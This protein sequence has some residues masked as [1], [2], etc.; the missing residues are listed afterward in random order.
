[1]ANIRVK[2]AEAIRAQQEREYAI[3]RTCVEFGL[4]A[5]FGL[6]MTLMFIIVHL[7]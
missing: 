5:G 4:S 1:M 2:D 7:L 6:M 3:V